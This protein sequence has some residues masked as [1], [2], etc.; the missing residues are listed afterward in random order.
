MTYL[1][2]T[3]C[4]ACRADAPKVS[5]A[6]LTEL[7]LEL[8]EWRVEERYAEKQLERIFK[9]KNFAQALAF[10]NDVGELAESENHHPAILTEWGRVTVT[11][12]T[13]K[14]GG[15]HKNDFIMAARTDQLYPD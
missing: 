11:W 3:A 9:F 14:I 7:M 10:T 6:E 1:I 15:L 5:D 2:E 8:P 13:H 12:W 4:E